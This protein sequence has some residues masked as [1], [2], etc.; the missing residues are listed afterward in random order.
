M[1]QATETTTLNIRNIDRRAV[2]RIKRAA[3]LRDM[4]VGEFL[5]HLIDIHDAVRAH[6]DAGDAALQAELVARG[7]Q[8]VQG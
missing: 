8:T 2:E 7:L 3:H 5:A 1:S 4:T 6:A